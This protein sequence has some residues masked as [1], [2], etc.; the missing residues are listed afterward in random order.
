MQ[1]YF[2]TQLEKKLVVPKLCQLNPRERTQIDIDEIQNWLSK[3]VKFKQL[4]YQLLQLLSKYLASQVF[5]ENQI[6]SQNE[7]NEEYR[8]I[9]V[10]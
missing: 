8:F 6:V 10:Y 9:I 7:K 2:Q 4:N 1:Y 5:F 3:L